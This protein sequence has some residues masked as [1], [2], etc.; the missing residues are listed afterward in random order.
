MA[1]ALGEVHGMAPVV[2]GRLSSCCLGVEYGPVLVKEA[3]V[4]TEVAVGVDSV[5][6]SGSEP[7]SEPDSETDSELEA[8]FGPVSEDYRDTS[9]P[10]PGPGS[11]FVLDVE[12]ATVTVQVDLE[13]VVG[14][15]RHSVPE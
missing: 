3:G 1:G 4:V 14:E 12:S 6:E 13:V 15:G 10:A 8:E 7:G 2:G 9:V 11:V 5:S